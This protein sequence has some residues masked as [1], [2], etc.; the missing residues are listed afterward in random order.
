MSPEHSLHESSQPTAQ[1]ATL[2]GGAEQAHVTGN[3]ESVE[4]FNAR[5]A[6][7]AAIAAAVATAPAGSLEL[8]K[9]QIT[10][11]KIPQQ[12][13]IARVTYNIVGMR[14]ALDAETIGLYDDDAVMRA[15]FFS[16]PADILPTDTQDNFG[17]A[18]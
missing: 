15:E 8:N 14:A 9:I 7:A 16:Q 4:V 12:K 11:E 13:V 17:L 18:S 10:N 5:R 1:E 3:I 2:L 6:A